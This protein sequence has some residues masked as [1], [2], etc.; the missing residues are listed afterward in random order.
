MEEDKTQ[1]PTQEQLRKALVERHSLQVQ[2]K[3]EKAHVAIAGLGGLGSN[4]AVNLARLGVGSLHLIDFD[5]VELSNLN[6]QYYFIEHIGMYKTNAIKNVLEQINP[7]I[8]IK[9]SCVKLNAEN[10][11]AYLGEDNIICEAFDKAESKAM[12]VNTVIE[13]L[14]QSRV[15]SAS[16]MAGYGS[17]NNIV[18]K[19]LGNRLYICGD[20][21]TD[22]LD[23]TGLMS[24]RVAVCAGHQSNKILEIILN[25]N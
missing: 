17:A 9:T 2:Q 25:E 13:K 3:I 18:T 21:T 19:Q 1:I 7:Y 12:L 10:I 23:G 22:I 14:P 6:R 11:L 24:P 20:Q 15:V 5:K 16:G 4:V 8:K